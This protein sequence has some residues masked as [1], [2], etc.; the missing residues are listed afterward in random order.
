MNNPVKKLVKIYTD[1]ACSGNPGKGGWAA[2][3]IYQGHE[4]VVSGYSPM[5][6]NNIMEL[7]AALEGLKILKEKCSVE[8]YSD[9]S[10]LINAF[11]N[12]WIDKWV[13]N[14]WKTSSKSP[15][16]NEKLWR[17]LLLLSDIHEI[18]WIKV[19]GHANDKYN[20]ICDKLAVEQINKNK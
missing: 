14:G 20:N 7:T 8:L 13:D 3:L 11:R 6:T 17:E 15:V 19:K 9:S 4:K 10:Y 2:I 5:T 16:K 12:K 1:G 18:T